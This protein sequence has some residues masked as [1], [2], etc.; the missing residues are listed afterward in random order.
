[1][2][3]TYNSMMGNDESNT[4]VGTVSDDFINGCEGA[5]VITGK[6]GNDFIIGSDG[7]DQYTYSALP[8][9][10]VPEGYHEGVDAIID[11]TRSEGDKIDLSALSSVTDGGLTFTG[12]TATPYAAYYSSGV[13][14]I[15]SPVVPGSDWE[16]I[17]PP[18]NRLTLKVDLDGNAQDEPE[19]MAL[20]WGVNTLTSADFIF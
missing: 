9:S 16:W 11:F 17:L 3:N 6:G 2:T 15:Y 5:D 19:L 12:T 18:D 14:S 8:A 7:A 4:L 13:N 1:M 10:G 20:I